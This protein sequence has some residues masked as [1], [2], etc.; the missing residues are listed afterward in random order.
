MDVGQ[1]TTITEMKIAKV[2]DNGFTI[3]CDDIAL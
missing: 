1:P 2:E 3:H